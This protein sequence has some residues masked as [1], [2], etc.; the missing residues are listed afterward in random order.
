MATSTAKRGI[1]VSL[2]CLRRVNG[3]PLRVKTRSFHAQA[4][5]ALFTR[6]RKMNSSR[7]LSTETIAADNSIDRQSAV[8]VVSTHKGGDVEVSALAKGATLATRKKPVNGYLNKVLNARVYDVAIDTP[9]Q[10]A[11]N[12]SNDL[13]NNVFLKREDLQPV[14]SFK[15]R[16]A[17]NK[18]TS[19]PRC[20]LER[21][22]V[23]CS[24][25]NHAQ[26]VALSAKKLG[27]KAVIVMPLA[28]P[29]IKVNAVRTHGGPT[30]SIRLHGVNYDE[31]SDE[32]NRLVLQEG[33]T[34]IHPFDDPE[35]IAG[36]GT[37]GMEILKARNGQALDIV[38]AC[39]GGGGLVAGVAAYI[40]QVR[41]EVKVISVE[42]EDAAGL[43]LSMKAGQ[44]IPLS[45]V[46]LFADGAAVR[47][48]G[49][50][51]FRVATQYVDGMMTV[52]TDEICQACYFRA[53]KMGFN[54]TRCIMEPAGALAI[55]GMRKYLR[56]KGLVGHTAVAICSGANMDFD[57]LRFV[58]ERADSSETL[59]S[60]TI[61]ERPGAF[62]ELYSVVFPRNVT[63][64]SY[65]YHNPSRADMIISFQAKPGIARQDDALT[66]IH[67][68]RSRGMSVMDLSSNELAKVHARH[69]VGGRAPNVKNELLYR[70]EFPESPGALSRFL[71]ALSGG[72]NVSLFHYRNHGSDFGRV[73]AGLQVPPEE[74]AEFQEFLSALGYTYY[75]E[76]RNPVYEQ[77]FKSGFNRS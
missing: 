24:A 34:L 58:S 36:Q 53:I 20:A 25:G 14:H 73:L 18:M 51:T 63:E 8:E 13:G 1:D 75:D 42:P 27:V 19:L 68:L 47:I 65:R 56:E 17:Y 54:D 5:P 76:S 77:F 33:L 35:V 43:T 64:F 72:W 23:A 50:E 31:A 26:G 12:M 37:I 61:P 16:G 69:M 2:R 46:G 57:R 49:G 45:S 59:I 38:F 60:V 9:L 15:L 11:V 3:W 32:A 62:Q 66:V 6:S 30:V 44:V 48:T 4:G 41:P 67:D 71:A 40:K 29:M 74:S 39:C 70:F 7:S 52:N 22:V 21:G 10:R 28:T 55:A